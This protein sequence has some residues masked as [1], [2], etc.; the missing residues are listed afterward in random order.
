M[1]ALFS[2]LCDGPFPLNHLHSLAV[3]PNLAFTH[4]E[5]RSGRLRA[6]LIWKA[7]NRLI[8]DAEREAVL[9]CIVIDGKLPAKL[10]VR[11]LNG[12]DRVVIEAS[13]R[14]TI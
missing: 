3:Q 14:K 10:T 1:A 5:L 4:D 8:V 7:L 12:V 6:S 11:Q 13:I 2:K 9:I